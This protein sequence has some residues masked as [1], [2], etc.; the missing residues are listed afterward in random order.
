LTDTITPK[1][2]LKYAHTSGDVV[3]QVTAPFFHQSLY[4]TRADM[5]WFSTEV[6]AGYD[7]EQTDPIIARLVDCRMATLEM[8]CQSGMPFILSAALQA[9][10]IEKQESEAAESYESNDPFQ[11]YHGTYTVDLGATTMITNFAL[12]LANR[13][14]TD[15]FTNSITPADI[16]VLGR[17][18]KVSFVLKLDD[19]TR[20][21]DTYMK[22]GH[23][24]VANKA[25]SLIRK[26]SNAII[27]V[28]K[29]CL[30]IFIKTPGL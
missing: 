25:A 19:G 28:P 22:S 17:D 8:K 2:A 23:A 3:E 18:G 5:P 1:T 10:D 27:I 9:I 21:W 15:D 20:L 16:P 13:L 26:P 12:S 6:S 30:A 7:S 24:S 14:D 29:R 4:E 11:F